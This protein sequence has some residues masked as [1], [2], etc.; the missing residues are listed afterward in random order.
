[1][2]VEAPGHVTLRAD[3]RVAAPLAAELH[4]LYDRSC[5]RQTDRDSERGV[6]RDAAAPNG[7]IVSV[8]PEGP[9]NVEVLKNAAGFRHVS[10]TRSVDRNSGGDASVVRPRTH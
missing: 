7:H 5:H 4:V 10:R 9:H 3:A 6:G 1:M 2:D 8:D